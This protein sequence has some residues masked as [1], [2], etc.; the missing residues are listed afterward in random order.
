MCVLDCAGV[1]QA[2]EVLSYHSQIVASKIA[3]P[4]AHNKFV[5]AEAIEARGTEGPMSCSQAWNDYL[6]SRSVC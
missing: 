3:R 5:C 2:P 4:S 6:Q 1:S